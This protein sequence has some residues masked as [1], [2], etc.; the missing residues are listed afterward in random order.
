MPL[1]L[2]TTKELELARLAALPAPKFKLTSLASS[3]SAVAGKRRGWLPAE[4]RG[5]ERRKE[6]RERRERRRGRR[7]AADMW[8]WVKVNGFKSS[9]AKDLWFWRSIA[10]TKL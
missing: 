6:K 2:L 9:M 1:R 3:S 4:E 7:D 10:K 5:E 8:A